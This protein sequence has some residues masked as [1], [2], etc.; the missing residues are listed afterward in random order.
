MD[1]GILIWI[2]GIVVAGVGLWVLLV[3]RPDG[4]GPSGD[5][6]GY[7]AKRAQQA[8]ERALNEFGIALD[9]TSKSV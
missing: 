6:E 7:M 8:I 2:A 5:V 3:R 4:A 1:T 9:G